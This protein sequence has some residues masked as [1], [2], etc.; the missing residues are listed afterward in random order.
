MDVVNYPVLFAEMGTLREET[1]V[2]NVVESN[3]DLV[4][5]DMQLLTA[6]Q[7]QVI[8]TQSLLSGK[9]QEQAKK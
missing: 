5:M 7:M 2:A 8:P 6:L 1:C 9:F 3:I 4:A